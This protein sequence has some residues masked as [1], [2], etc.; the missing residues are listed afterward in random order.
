VKE[1][2]ITNNF[3]ISFMFFYFKKKKIPNYIGIFNS[4]FNNY[5]KSVTV[6][7]IL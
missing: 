6:P 1:K 3:N 5:L 2:M 7:S 4:I